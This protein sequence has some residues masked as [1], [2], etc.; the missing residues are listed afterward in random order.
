M[1]WT[2]FDKSTPILPQHIM[3]LITTFN[4][5]SLSSN[6]TFWCRQ[7]MIYHIRFAENIVQKII[8][9]LKS[10]SQ[11]TNISKLIAELI[12]FPDTWYHSTWRHSRSILFAI[13]A[14]YLSWLRVHASQSH[15]ALWNFSRT[16]RIN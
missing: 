13:C 7:N 5:I 8:S 3:V 10:K 4:N 15:C 14:F 11:I 9:F 1:I 2:H 6:V 16:Y 12:C